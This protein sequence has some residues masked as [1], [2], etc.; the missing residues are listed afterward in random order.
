[1]KSV[2]ADTFFCLALLDARDE[3]HPQVLRY[4]Q[5]S[6]DFILTTRWVFAEVA[7]A[8]S[9]TILRT[10]VVELLMT[11]ESDPSVIVAGSSEDLYRRGLGLYANHS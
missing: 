11:L 6:R 3:H 2:F 8:M 9:G 7:N 5:H 4:L 10:A 1:M